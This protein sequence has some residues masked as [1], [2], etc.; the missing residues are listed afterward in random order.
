MKIPKPSTPVILLVSGGLDSI[1]TWLYLMKV[2][3]LI[4]YPLF[5]RRGQRRQTLEENAVNYFSKLY[6]KKFPKYWT[7][8]FKLDCQI[9]PANIRFPI[10]IASNNQISSTGQLQ[11]IPLYSLI[12]QAQAIEY[13]HYLKHTSNITA[14]TIF[15]SFMKSDGLVMRDE[16]LTA[17]RSNNV[18]ICNLL[19]DYSWQISSLPI[20]KEIGLFYDKS[21]FIRWGYKEKLP[22]EKTRSCIMWD[23]KH[24]GSCLSCKFRKYSFFKA[25]VPDKTK[26]IDNM[27]DAT[28][29]SAT[30]KTDDNSFM[31]KVARVYHNTHWN[32]GIKTIINRSIKQIIKTTS[33][34][35]S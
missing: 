32:I 5:I 35:H 4:V 9:P 7:K 19:N 26:Y 13:A 1:I 20:E 33:K 10:T 6:Q 25:N 3:H 29:D 18:A 27:Y 21:D 23:T 15:C 2:Y 31:Y 30:H 11:G 12:L 17:M 16:T 8:P 24:C 14:K 34:H 22:L 28:M